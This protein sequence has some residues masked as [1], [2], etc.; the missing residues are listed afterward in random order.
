MSVRAWEW[1]V[2]LSFSVDIDPSACQTA[3]VP[4]TIPISLYS[5]EGKHTTNL[6][7]Y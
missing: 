6:F 1:L 3:I 7:G 5:E 2:V 4:S